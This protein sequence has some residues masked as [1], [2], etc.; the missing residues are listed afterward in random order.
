MEMKKKKKR[1]KW[2]GLQLSGGR[3]SKLDLW[4]MRKKKKRGKWSGFQFLLQ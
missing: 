1:G 3:G 2:S 4:W